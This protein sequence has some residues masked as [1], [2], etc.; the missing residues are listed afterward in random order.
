MV[1]KPARDAAARF[2]GFEK[3]PL[4]VAVL[5]GRARCRLGQ[6]AELKSGDVLQL[7]RRI[8]EPFELR[9][10]P[11]LLGRVE[12]VADKEAIAVK[13]IEIPEGDDGPSR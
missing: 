13:L 1:R 5:V 4:R 12:A 7:D 3:V 9:A 11:I 8:G 10:G 6:L 2:A